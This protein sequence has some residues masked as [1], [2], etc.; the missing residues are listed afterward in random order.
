MESA[1]RDFHENINNKILCVSTEALNTVN[2]PDYIKEYILTALNCREKVILFTDDILYK[3]LEGIFKNNNELIIEGY[4]K[5]KLKI[6]TYN[7]VNFNINC[8]ELL[9][10]LSEGAKTKEKIKI[11]WDFKNTAKKIGKFDVVNKSVDI[12]FNYTNYLVSNLFYM[13]NSNYNYQNLTDFCNKFNVIS[14]FDRGREITL[15]DKSF[16]DKAMWMLQSNAQ[17]KYEKNTLVLFNE[18]FSTIPK[19]QNKEQYKTSVINKLKDVCDVDFCLIYASDREK[20]NVLSVDSLYGITKKHKYFMINDNKLLAYQKMY[21]EKIISKNGC[22]FTNIDDLPDDDLK[23]TFK[24]IGVDSCIG[25]YVEYYEK[26]KGVMWI[27]RYENRK[28]MLKSDIQYIECI[29]KTAFYLIQ[30]H[31]KFLDMQ[32]KL[33]ENEK[34]RAIAEMAGGIAHDINNILTPIMGCIQLIKDNFNDIDIMKQLDMIEMC[35]CDGMNI[36]NKVKQ[37]SKQYNVEEKVELLSIDEMLMDCIELTKNK[38]LTQSAFN[39]IKIKVVTEIDSGCVING[40]VT[41]IREVF[42]NLISNAVDA[43]PNG[44]IIEVVSHKNEKDVVIEIRDNGIGMDEEI[45]KRVFE[46]FFTTKGNKGSGLG[47]SISFKIIQSH[48][49]NFEINSKVNLGTCFKIK[50]PISKNKKIENKYIVENKIA[51][52]GNILI[53]DDEERIRNVISDILKSMTGARI[54]SSNGDNVISELQRRK[55]DIIVCDFS[56]PE[57]DGLKIAEIVKKYDA[58]I[59]FC[60]MTGWVG[61]FE[62]RKMSNVDF[63][64]N[65]PVS[66]I[67]I[68]NMFVKYKTIKV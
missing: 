16:I 56:M 15:K 61:N 46:P 22:I 29:C 2:L 47:L 3:D 32:N 59:F 41:E 45:T 68:N 60:L 7:P 9:E 43:M 62:K 25:I 10:V 50:L 27:G 19:T 34:M 58:S 57:K 28:I 49:G 67:N 30:D 35:A 8:S 11:V 4:K 31:F 38:W 21:N 48:G 39:G 26:V 51:F 12:I 18:I 55:Y 33:I 13:N 64:L 1:S 52:K 42:I 14:I 66:K 20:E 63:I 53:I 6:V 44:G 5:S 65:K 40:N 23:E 17:L 24:K 36:T 54:K 37:I